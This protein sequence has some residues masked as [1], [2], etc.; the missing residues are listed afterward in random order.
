MV[1]PGKNPL[2]AKVRIKR[3]PTKGHEFYNV[4]QWKWYLDGM[5]RKDYKDQMQIQVRKLL[6]RAMVETFALFTFQYDAVLEKYFPHLPMVHDACIGRVIAI[7]KATQA[8]CVIEMNA[9]VTEIKNTNPTLA[10]KK[11]MLVT[12]FTETCAWLSC[13]YIARMLL[14]AIS[15][16]QVCKN[17]NSHSS[18]GSNFVPD[19]FNAFR[20]GQCFERICD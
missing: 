3:H 20:P 9:E 15:T 4:D 6:N 11:P 19:G 14:N 7:V 12:R 17:W 8:K 18:L 10:A 2:P 13:G 1:S 5:P 16:Y